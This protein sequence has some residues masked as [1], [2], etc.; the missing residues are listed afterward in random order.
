MQQ[1]ITSLIDLLRGVSILYVEDEVAMRQTLR[2]LLEKFTPLVEEASNGKEAFQKWQIEPADLIITDLNMPVM[3]GL[4]LVRKIKE[5]DPFQKII[6]LSAYGDM[7]NLLE[8]IN[9]GVDGYILK[10]LDI[11]AFFS[12]LQRVGRY[13]RLEKENKEYKEYLEKQLELYKRELEEKNRQI[14]YKLQY[15]SLTSLPNKNRLQLDF[16]SKKFKS[17]IYVDIDNM[18]FVNINFGFHVGDR[19]IAQIAKKIGESLP[20]D[21]FLYHVM[22]DEFAILSQQDVHSSLVVAKKIAQAIEEFKIPDIG[23]NLTS[24]LAVIPVEEKIPFDKAHLTI[25]KAKESDKRVLCFKEDFFQEFHKKDLAFWIQKVQDGLKEDRFIP[26]FQPII[27]T[28][29]KK[30]ER[31]EVLS[32]L[33]DNE[34][35]VSP[36]LFLD[37]V[38]FSGL[39][40]KMTRRIIQKSFETFAS[41]SLSFSL[42]ISQ[43][44]LRS[45]YLQSYLL[46][47][48]EKYRIEPHRVVLE[49]LES[50]GNEEYNM[51]QFKKLKESGF[52]IAIDDFGTQGANFLRLHQW[53][54]DF[55]KIDGIFIKDIDKNKD[56]FYIVETIIHYAKLKGIKT[57]AEYVHNDK[58]AQKLEKIGV[59]YVQGFYFGEPRKELRKENG[60]QSSP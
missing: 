27:N 40:P 22:N 17:M 7:K 9:V 24:T 53:P 56:S 16:Q 8:A 33:K 44:D 50:M 14:L 23:F 4:E 55:L 35:I 19:A 30:I 46:E 49:I 43:E 6:V 2:T 1:E 10:P 47:Q 20:S 36:A 3:G 48:C 25:K 54:V 12:T 13:I 26:Y 60:Y 32:R 5:K 31:Y 18:D 41:T 39:M 28:T 42:N 38:R 34:T 37:A 58:V 52:L 59:D 15:D 57:I 11:H 51:L 45:N 29:T 21:F